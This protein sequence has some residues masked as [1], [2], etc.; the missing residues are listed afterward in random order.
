M[1]LT[2]HYLNPMISEKNH[3][4]KFWFF[5]AKNL[6]H[7]KVMLVLFWRTRFVVQIC[8]YCSASSLLFSVLLLKHWRFCDFDIE[9]GH[10]MI[11]FTIIK[12]LWHHHPLAATFPYHSSSCLEYTSSCLSFVSL[13]VISFYFFLSPC[14]H[15]S[16]LRSLHPSL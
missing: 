6:N 5:T 8:R 14:L 12:H 11:I 10:I 7:D 1:L 3:P 13:F 4:S 15:S 16:S 9:L 2:R